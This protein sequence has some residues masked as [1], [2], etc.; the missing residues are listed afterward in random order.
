LG[1][2]KIPSLLNKLERDRFPQLTGYLSNHH[3]VIVG[4]TTFPAASIE[5]R[6]SCIVILLVYLSATAM[7][8]EKYCCARRK[9]PATGWLPDD[10]QI[11]EVLLLMIDI[12]TRSGE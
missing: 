11:A 7:R 4:N 5:Q 9:Y 6:Y 3:A 12:E 1:K 10:Y 8:K 2:S